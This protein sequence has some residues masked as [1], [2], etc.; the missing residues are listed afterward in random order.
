MAGLAFVLK[1]FADS[2]AQGIVLVVCCAVVGFYFGEFIEAVVVV[3]RYQLAGLSSPLAYAV[4]ALIVLVVAIGVEVKAI[5][6]YLL[7]LLVFALLTVALL[8]VVSL[9]LALAT[10]ILAWLVTQ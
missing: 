10:V 3:V 9:V 6:G 1:G 5:G 4:A 2:A 7:A 8:V